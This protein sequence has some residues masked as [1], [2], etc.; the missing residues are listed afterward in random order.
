MTDYRTPLITNSTFEEDEAYDSDVLLEKQPLKEPPLYA[1]VMLNDDYTPMDFVVFILMSEF[2]HNEDK[3]MEI[4]LNVHHQGKG[5]A[6]VYSRDIA[7]T[8]ASQV[9][10]MAKQAGFPLTTQIE[11]STD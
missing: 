3:A 7:E 6:G 8:K 2:H 5:I 9:N 10:A 1:V 11:P 4:M